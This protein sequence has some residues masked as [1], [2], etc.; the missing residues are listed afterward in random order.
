MTKVT[1]PYQAT[2]PITVRHASQYFLLEGD[3]TA[4][5]FIDPHALILKVLNTHLN[6]SSIILFRKK[7]NLALEIVATN[8]ILI[9][10][11]LLLFFIITIKT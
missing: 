8:L 2:D 4:L 7:N 9:D 5:E 10:L 6:N 3:L 11:L 1:F